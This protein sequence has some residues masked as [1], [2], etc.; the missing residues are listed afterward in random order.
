M[1]RKRSPEQVE[2]QRQ[3]V[4]LA[5]KARYKK[6]VIERTH[7]GDFTMGVCEVQIEEANL[8]DEVILRFTV[9]PRSMDPNNLE[10]DRVSHTFVLHPIH[11][12]A[13]L[14]ALMLANIRKGA[15]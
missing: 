13:I 7:E 12:K 10:G 9:Q 1:V 4:A 11:W 2:V 3:I 5:K 6:N 15:G 14:H 8:G